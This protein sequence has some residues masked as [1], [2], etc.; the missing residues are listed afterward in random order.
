MI[1][2]SF[3]FN[4]YGEP[5]IRLLGFNRQHF[6]FLALSFQIFVQC[7]MTNDISYTAIFLL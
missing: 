4:H 3:R 2:P 7:N 6:R 1:Y 5:R